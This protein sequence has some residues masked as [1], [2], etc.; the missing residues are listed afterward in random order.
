LFFF[1]WSVDIMKY[2]TSSF[3]KDIQDFQTISLN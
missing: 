1:Q 3:S 2:E